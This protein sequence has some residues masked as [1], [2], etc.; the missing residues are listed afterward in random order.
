MFR[1]VEFRGSRVPSFLPGSLGEGRSP[2]FGQFARVSLEMGLLAYIAGMVILCFYQFHVGDLPWGLAY[3]FSHQARGHKAFLL[4]QYSRMGWWYY[5]PVAFA[6]KTPVPSLLLI[7]GAV[8]QVRKGS[9][10]QAG[11]WL[12]PALV[13]FYFGAFTTINMGLRYVLPAFPFLLIGAGGALAWCLRGRKV[14]KIIGVV[15]MVWYLIGNLR[16]YPHYRAYFNELAGGPE[17]GI[18]LLGDSNIDWGQDL[19]GLKKLVI[20]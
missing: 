5:F 12:V 16:I 13:I 10:L 14:F 18:Y 3:G 17:K 15:F 11:F 4:G 9:W 2:G 6:L 8:I 7:L 19:I 20:Q 1:E